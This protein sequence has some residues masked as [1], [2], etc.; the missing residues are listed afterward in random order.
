MNRVGNNLEQSWNQVRI[1]NKMRKK[2]VATQI[3]K[4]VQPLA[5]SRHCHAHSLNL[6]CDDWIRNCLDFDCLE[7][8][9]IQNHLTYHTK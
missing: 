6:A 8:D 5:L 9:W 4:D 2:G 7:I 1:E 3:K